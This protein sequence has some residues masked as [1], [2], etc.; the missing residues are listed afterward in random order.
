[1]QVYGLIF[2]KTFFKNTENNNLLILNVT[3]LF[4]T[5]KTFMEPL[6]NWVLKNKTSIKKER[7]QRFKSEP[8]LRKPKFAQCVVNCI[9][10]IKMLFG[11]STMNLILL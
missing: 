11:F 2:F 6:I 3:F 8:L 5:Y 10:N 9:I 7:K 1:M 4:L